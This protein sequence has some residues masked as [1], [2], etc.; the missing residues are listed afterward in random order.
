[1][2]K[3]WLSNYQD[4]VPH[5]VDP[6]HYES[7]D[8]LFN[9]S[10]KRFADKIA[11]VNFGTEITYKELHKRSLDFAAYLQN[12]LNL[13]KGDKFAIMLP[14]LL[15]YTVALFGAIKAGLTVV[16]INPLYTPRE[17]LYQVNDACVETIL[18]LE[19]FA[20]TVQKIMEVSSLQN[21]IITRLGDLHSKPKRF[22]MNFINKYIKK[23]V[24]SYKIS[25]R[26]G[27][28]ETLSKGSC[29][30]F[31][32]IKFK[33]SDI[34]FLQ[35][36]GGTTGVAKGAI[37][38]HRNLL[39]NL[40]QGA[41]W[42]KPTLARGKEIIVTP[43]P[44]Y[45][46]FS[47]TANCLTFLHMGAKNILITNPK[48]ID[49]F[50]KELKGIKFSVISGVNT[51]FNALLSNRKF[52]TL[53]FSELKLTLG[54]GMSVQKSIAERWQKITK[55]PLLEAYGLT[56]ASPAVSINPVYLKR[57]NGSIG[58]PLPS[59]EITIRDQAG[60]EVA[61]GK[62]GELWIK[63]PQ[64]MD[65][66]WNKEEENNK[67]FSGSWLKTGDVAYINEEGYIYIVDRIK[68]MVLVSGFNVYPN[69]VEEALVSHEYVNEAGVVGVLG[70]D[71]NERVIAFVSLSSGSINEGQLRNYCRKNLARYKVPKKIFFLK[72]LPKTSVG[73]ISRKDLKELARNKK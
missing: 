51:L 54:G 60:D 29:Y 4:G 13:K 7:L 39:A 27:F 48:D 23:N 8:D 38:S 58:F 55:C 22:L 3:I 66:Y 44:L 16:N 1:M 45:H 24:E 31:I 57:Y 37:L 2:E 72:E 71:G 62:E 41:A 20:K 9:R 65:G 46:I 10:C 69:E 59:T 28:M 64:V 67:V 15:Q 6:D 68:D 32:E 36:T 50:I 12:E 26:L 33:N 40:A 52:K 17:L 21:V 47:L 18:V 49:K 30:K 56:E 73:K 42:I 63:G 14:N 5:D 43:L 61:T 70:D 19:N 35:Y 53:D 25:N 34:A 11:Y